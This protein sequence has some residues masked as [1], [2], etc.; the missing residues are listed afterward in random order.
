[1]CMVVSIPPSSNPIEKTKSID[2]FPNGKQLVY[3]AGT[4]SGTGF[5][6]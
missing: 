6:P 4:R 1:M 3:P 5:M 2:G